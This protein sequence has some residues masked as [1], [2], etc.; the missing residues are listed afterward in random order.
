MLG[1]NCVGEVVKQFSAA[2]SKR[3]ARC[4]KF[5]ASQT[6]PIIPLVDYKTAGAQP[7]TL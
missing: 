2:V 6:T 5:V 4:L 3:S 1:K 7:V